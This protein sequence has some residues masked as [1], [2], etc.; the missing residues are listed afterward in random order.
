MSASNHHDR[1]AIASLLAGL[2][3]SLTLVVCLTLIGQ[4]DRL[5]LPN[6]FDA[7]ARTAWWQS[8]TGL[9]VVMALS[10]AMCLLFALYITLLYLLALIAIVANRLSTAQNVLRLLP[11]SFRLGLAGIVGASI[12]LTSMGHAPQ[13]SDAPQVTPS[14]AVDPSLPTTSQPS[15]ATTTTTA[16]STTTSMIGSDPAPPNESAQANAETP[17]ALPSPQDNR[18]DRTY[19][20]QPG[21]H[22]WSIA[23]AELRRRNP[24]VHLSTREIS[25]YWKKLCTLNRA[26]LR[27]P[28]NLDLIYPGDSVVLPD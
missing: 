18:G 10:R 12:T 6:M 28:K 26:N 9:D 4:V 27:D 22:L 23:E 11:P 2:L 1:R 25:R 3:T 15:V 17:V 14:S 20:I 24:D 8:R 21:D 16:R 7:S 19:V 13:G 5:R